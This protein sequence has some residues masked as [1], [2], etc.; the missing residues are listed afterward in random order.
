MTMLSTT[1]LPNEF[2][3]HKCIMSTDRDLM[4]STYSVFMRSQVQEIAIVDPTAHHLKKSVWV[5]VKQTQSGKWMAYNPDI[6]THGCGKSE[7]A[8]AQDFHDMM[9]GLYQELLNSEDQLAPHLKQ[10]LN[11]LKEIIVENSIT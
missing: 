5:F 10:E 9:I 4:E 11:Y 1:Q 7:I 6:M 3:T 2:M 8:A